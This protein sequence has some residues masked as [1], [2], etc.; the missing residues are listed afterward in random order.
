MTER[1]AWPLKR[2]TPGPDGT[3]EDIAVQDIAEREAADRRLPPPDPEPLADPRPRF[4]LAAFRLAALGLALV[5]A[6]ALAMVRVFVGGPESV[7]ELRARSGVDE[8]KE[9]AVGVKD[10]QPGVAFYDPADKMWKGFDVDMAYMI[11]EDLGFRSDE[12]KF[13]GMES[14]D[15]ARMQ[16]YDL[17]HKRVAVNVVI[18]SYSITKT[19]IDEGVVFAGPYLYTEQSVLTL[20]GHAPVA[21]FKDLTD[22]Q[23]CSLSTAT[24]L[25]GLE[26]AHAL[27]RS[28][29]RISECITEMR[30]GR[31]E[32]VSTDAAILAGYKAKYP[33]EFEHW[34][35]GYDATEKWGVN[36]GENQALKK[37]INLTLYRSLKD[38]KDDRW[39]KAFQDNLQVEVGENKNTPIAVATQP[40]VDRPNIRDLPWEDVFP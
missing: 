27:V 25:T 3:A 40:P 5:L 23:V 33:S 17:D 6:L 39:E 21:T 32:A 12:I 9:L 22:K 11:G 34:D 2:R 36:V 14:E 7:A 13:Y 35:L 18:A 15:R 37:L 20:K 10:D 4:N 26:A 1:F 30:A 8:W 24:S 16:A 31:V 38:P 19:R 28:K 29:N